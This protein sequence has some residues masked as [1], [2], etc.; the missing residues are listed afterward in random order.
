[1]EPSHEPTL[2]ALL[3]EERW[4][5]AL[6]RRLVRDAAAA[7]D[8]AQETWLRALRGRTALG[9]GPESPR[10][11]LARVMLNVWR[12]RGRS[13]GAR[14]RREDEHA[15]ELHRAAGRSSPS[16]R[17]VLERLELQRRLAAHVLA[18]DEPFRSTLV[19]RYFAGRSAAELAAESG[20]PAARV[21]QRLVR[22]RELLR[23]R[24]DREGEDW[25]PRFAVLLLPAAPPGGGV[26]TSP[27]SPLAPVTLPLLAMSTKSHAVSLALVLALAAVVVTAWLTLGPSR[28]VTPALEG[29]S[30]L[31]AIE[32]SGPSRAVA[33]AAEGPSQEPARRLPALALVADQLQAPA[34]PAS[35]AGRVLTSEDQRPLVG[36][37]VAL[38]AGGFDEPRLETR[39]GA[40]GHYTFDGVAPGRYSVAARSAD[41]VPRIVR[42]VEVAAGAAVQRDLALEPGFATELLVSDRDSG[43][44][45][46]GAQVTLVAGSRD[47]VVWIAERG[48]G[49]HGLTCT[50]DA[51]GRASP[52]GVARGV[53]QYIVRKEGHANGLG[54]ALLEPGAPALR[55]NLERGTAVTGVVRDHAGAPVAGV[56]VF[57]VAAQYQKRLEDHVLAQNGVLTDAHGSYRIGA[58]PRGVY[59][60]VALRGDG[61][62]TFAFDEGDVD[63]AGAAQELASVIVDRGADVTLDFALPVPG[64]VS[65]TVVDTEGHAIADATA[66]VSW[67]DFKPG[68]APFFALNRA[69]GLK[70]AI[71]HRSRADA[72]GRIILAPLRRSH[73]PLRVTV[74]CEG[75]AATELELDVPAGTRFEEAV[76]LR[77]LDGTLRGRVTGP[78]GG[79]LPG[80]HINALEQHGSRLG[81]AFGARTDH[82][83]VFEIR[84]PR[85][86]R[87]GARYHVAPFVV[88]DEGLAATPALRD[89][90]ECG[91]QDLDFVL[92]PRMRL[93]GL[94]VD[95]SGAP[96]RD[97]VV[98]QQRRGGDSESIPARSSF[99]GRW[100]PVRDTHLGDGRF[101]V[102]VDRGDVE[103]AWSAPG[104]DAVYLRASEVEAAR[105]VVLP[106]AGDL[107]G[108]VVDAWG[109][110]VADAVIALA[111]LDSAVYPVGTGF[112]PR[113][114]TDAGGRF[115]LARVP[116][117]ST[118]GPARPLGHLL[119]CPVQ[120][121]LPPLTRVPLPRDRA[122][123]LRIELPRGSPVSLHFIDEAGRAATGFAL[124]VDS[125]GWPLEPALEAHLVDLE[126]ERRGW[127]RDG[128]AEFTLAPGPYAVVLVDGLELRGRHEFTVA[129]GETA[130][131][132]HTFVTPR[133]R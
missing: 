10:S 76:V 27:S 22:A 130:V 93:E 23:E 55:I 90:V 59:Y 5:R 37:V 13:E 120:A 117:S 103:L 132:T 109:A 45:I 113:T 92:G 24:L 122:L 2:A 71:H 125:A 64:R 73:R 123:P 86:A 28:T 26:A 84:V 40:D 9:Q 102:F 68:N 46:E 79:P 4:L 133:E 107:A 16:A 83:G 47:S 35:V 6:G 75:Y 72:E 87:P 50:T 115:V 112:A 85:G 25:L 121:D 95:E 32:P 101:R 98:H 67:G 20:E 91:A 49:F 77:A 100:V 70:E 42:D 34:R 1:M 38:L 116:A 58:V 56:A 41:R 31:V 128:R 52:F 81:A 7:D 78:D 110:P 36:A 96:V 18:L 63:A 17:E 74:S 60:A 30:E 53:H 129:S 65:L 39:A 14:G 43:A 118:A 114:V 94:V 106:R 61:S 57:L 119:V 3:A 88:P 69:P 124:V 19:L 82:D 131:T 12:E 21:R 66:K 111:T 104:R 80:R 127:L 89:G 51:A 44:P 33:S 99:D 126:S 54:E 48:Y 11:W 8:L 108:V 62:G 97:F 29:R 15:R 105:R